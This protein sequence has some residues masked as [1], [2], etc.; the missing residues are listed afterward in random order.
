MCVCIYIYIYI[1]IYINIYIYIYAYRLRL[2]LNGDAPQSV[3]AVARICVC[4]YI[5][6]CI[7]VFNVIHIYI[8]ILLIYIHA[9]TYKFMHFIKFIYI[10]IYSAPPPAHSER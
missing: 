4:M 2:I 1:Y 8:P 6:I 5:Y 9:Y 7:Y 10:N 3:N